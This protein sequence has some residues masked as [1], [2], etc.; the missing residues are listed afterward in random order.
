M[1]YYQTKPFIF[2]NELI[3]WTIIFDCDIQVTTDLSGAIIDY[4]GCGYTKAEKL[5]QT[6]NK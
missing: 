3:G 2:R 5:L 6:L 4:S 1:T